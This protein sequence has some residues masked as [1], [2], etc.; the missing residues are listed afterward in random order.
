MITGI[1]TKKN[2]KQEK[3]QREFKEILTTEE[4]DPRF[5]LRDK[6]GGYLCNDKLTLKID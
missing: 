6:I 2:R 4:L 5:D 3:L 1:L